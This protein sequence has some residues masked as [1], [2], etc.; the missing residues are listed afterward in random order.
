MIWTYYQPDA[1]WIGR[2]HS[3]LIRIDTCSLHVLKFKILV[4]TLLLMDL[5]ILRQCSKAFPSC[6]FFQSIVSFTPVIV[7]LLI[8]D[9]IC[10][11]GWL[12]RCSEYMAILHFVIWKGRL[13]ALMELTAENQHCEELFRYSRAILLLYTI[14]L[15]IAKH[16][17]FHFPTRT[18]PLS[19]AM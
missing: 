16:S 13:F 1:D 4:S 5:R 6:C 7:Y 10:K 9:T 11:H 8:D 3:W 15:F 14:R 18:H 17:S 19:V 2:W 12:H